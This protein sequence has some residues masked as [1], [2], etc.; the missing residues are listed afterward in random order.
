MH[1][2]E[3]LSFLKNISASELPDDELVEK[4][5]ATSD[6]Q[7]LSDLYQRYMELVYGVCLKYLKDE[8]ESKDAVINIYEELVGKLQKYPVNNFKPWLYQLAKNHCLMKLR[9][10]KKFTKVQMDVSFMQNEETVHLNAVMEKEEH[11]NQLDFCMDQL[12]SEQKAVVTLF[13]LEGKC[14]NEITTITGIEWKNVR[15]FIQNGRR[16][17]KICMDKQISIS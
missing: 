4:Y 1:I 6:L 16:N 5:K 13:Y 7:V 8:E 3:N 10:D 2:F 11:F 17:L 12:V 14:Y 15:S 9:S